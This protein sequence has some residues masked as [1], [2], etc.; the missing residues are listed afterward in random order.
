[1]P[2]P[3]APA[4]FPSLID[5][6]AAE[7]GGEALAASDDFF[8][9][10]ENL[11]KSEPAVFD[12]E[13][14][15]ERGKWMDGWESRRKRVPG[16]DWCVV[17]LGI[18]GEIRAVDIDT[19]HFLGNHPAEASVDACPVASELEGEPSGWPWHPLVARYP[20][21]PGSQNL[22]SIQSSARVGHVRLNIF[23][24]GGVARL[25]VWGEPRPDLPGG[26][27]F[28]LAALVHGGRAVAC[29]DMFFGRMGNLI[30][31]GAP[32]NMGGGWETRR[33]RGPGHDWA[34]IRLATPGV[35]ERVEV[36]T[37]H[38]KGNYPDRCSVEAC[39]A[40]CEL[41]SLD[42]DDAEWRTLVGETRL[43]AHRV[44][45]FTDLE[46]LGPVDHVRLN[47]FPDGGV[48]RLRVWGRAAS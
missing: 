2:S 5:L 16:H 32:P 47:I 43:E 42:C 38:F 9:E 4:A 14:Y 22:A 34:V 7:V 45:E 30:L 17:K 44:H 48:A 33:R 20:L 8:A 37:M 24:D 6:A 26:G 12:P 28:D 31:P 21:R 19:S 15:T 23:P 1:M 11:L 27:V 35:V 25:R 39:R 40:V 10:K 18:P 46:G 41:G 13:R 29:S 3:S 36:D